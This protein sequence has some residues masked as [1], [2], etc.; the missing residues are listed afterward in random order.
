MR[1]S[2]WAS[3]CAAFCVRRL[4]TQR[5]PC[6]HCPFRFWLASY[7]PT[8][9][10]PAWCRSI[11]ER[12][13]LRILQGRR[14]GKTYTRG[15]NVAVNCGASARGARWANRRGRGRCRRAEGRGHRGSRG[16]GCGGGRRG[17]GCSGL[18]RRHRQRGAEKVDVLRRAFQAGVEPG[19][20]GLERRDGGL[21]GAYGGLES[22]DTR[23]D[24]NAINKHRGVAAAWDVS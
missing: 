3:Q 8:C 18:G 22:L 14:F 10:L 15:T 6:R 19:L 20:N 13:H 24:I 2:E 9:C 23:L 1:E 21:E 4:H 16:R 5:L 11:N 7:L 17:R 12:G